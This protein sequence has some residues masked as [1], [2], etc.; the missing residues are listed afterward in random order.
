VDPKNHKPA[1]G[2]A[3]AALI[4]GL[5]AFFVGLVPFLGFLLGGGAVVL[6]VLA[7]RK[8]QSKPLAIAG[9]ALGG[10]ATLTS[11]LTTLLLV[12]GLVAT[13]SASESSSLN[14]APTPSATPTS[15][16][17]EEAEPEEPEEPAEPE[18]PQLTVSES[19]AVRSGNSYLD[20]SGFSRSGLIGQLEYEGYSTGDATFAVDYIAPDWNKEAAESAESYLAYSSFSRQG[21]ID[22][23]IYEGFSQAEAE[24][25]VTAAGY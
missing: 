8:N 2:L 18:A 16:S 22:Q 21:L 24:Y 7:L 3:V 5:V 25:G 9:L 15:P 4:T 1:A 19:N 12:V 14:V 23:L 10:I 11:F 20:Y 13:P 6:G 17:L